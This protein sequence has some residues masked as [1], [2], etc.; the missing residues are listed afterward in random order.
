MLA[1]ESS[2]T[3]VHYRR[4]D[5]PGVERLVGAGVH[6]GSSPADALQYRH[7]D[8]VVVG[9]ANSAGQ[10]ALHLAEYA[11]RV[12][13]VCRTDSLHAG[14]SRYLSERIEAHERVVVITNAYVVEVRG[15]QHLETVIVAGQ[16]HQQTVVR[17]DGMFVLIGAQPISAGVAGWLQRDRHGFLV[18]GLFTVSRDRHGLDPGRPR[19][20]RGRGR[21]LQLVIEYDPQPPYASGSVGKAEPET[22]Q[23]AT[24]LLTRCVA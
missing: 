3:G 15:E 5:A 1:P 9:G 6:Y 17:A 22:K 10:A 19:G 4:L 11:S 7:R 24:E 14:M 13:L 23:R 18:T 16:D 12:T 8:V 20:G 21:A 2:A